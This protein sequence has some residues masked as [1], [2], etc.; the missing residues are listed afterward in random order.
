MVLLN[1]QKIDQI[2]VESA[3]FNDFINE[4]VYVSQPPEYENHE[5][6]VYVCKLNGPSM[7]LNKDLIMVK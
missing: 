6:F 1:S 5:N 3:F 7:I 4:E 2:D